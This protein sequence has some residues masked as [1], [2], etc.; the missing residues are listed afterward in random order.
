MLMIDINNG[1]TLQMVIHGI[2]TI[3]A[4][5]LIGLLITKIGYKNANYK[6]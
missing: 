1:T 5:V 6:L 2:I 3:I 4:W